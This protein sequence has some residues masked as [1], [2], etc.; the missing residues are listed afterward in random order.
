MSTTASFLC[1]K[2]INNINLDT[3][4]KEIDNFFIVNKCIYFRFS[5]F[6][7]LVSINSS[8]TMITL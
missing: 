3:I 7:Y 8:I 4:Y 5:I 1:V 6:S 2:A